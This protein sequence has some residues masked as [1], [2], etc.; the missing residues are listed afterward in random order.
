VLSDEGFTLLHA[1]RLR[2]LLQVEELHRE[3][4]SHTAVIVTQLVD[5]GLVT[6]VRASIRITTKG[7][8]LHEAWARVPSGTAIEDALRRGYDR[9][10]RLNAEFLR[11]CHDWQVRPG[12]VPNVHDDV[13]YDWAVVD[14]LGRID[15][16]V[17]PILRRVA[18]SLERFDEYPRRLRRARKRVEDGEQDWFTSPRVDSYHTV[19]MQV[20]EDLLLA[21]GLERKDEPQP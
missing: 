14:R 3:H 15:E 19:W 12:N 8:E 9:F 21:L 7:R 16:R 18:R 1:V 11:L 17:A 4:G 5:E 13:R 20:H 2:G 6:P 10:L